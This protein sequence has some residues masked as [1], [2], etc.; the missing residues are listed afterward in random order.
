LDDGS[1]AAKD[2]A[3]AKQ[4]DPHDPTPWLYSAIHEQQENRFNSAV[5]ELRQSLRLNDNRQVYRSQFL[6]DEDRAVRSANLAKIYQH[7]GM[8]EVAVREATRAVEGDYSNASAHLFLA[9]SFDAL[10]DP[11]EIALRYETAWFNEQLLAHLLSP[12]GG[13]PLSQFV[14]Q[15]EYS[16]LLEADR[17]GGSAIIEARSD[18]YRSAQASVFGTRG[19]S[20]GGLDW[21]YRRD[22]GTRV[23]NDNTLREVSGQMK[24]QASAVDVIYGLVKWRNQKNGDLLQN[25]RNEPGNPGLRFEEKQEPGLALA[26]WNRR[27]AP[28]VHTLFLGG[29]L[30]A[31]Q[32][33]NTP[34]FIP[35]LLVR[36]PG[37]LQPEFLRPTA[38]GV[39][40]YT[41]PELRNATI[42]P[43]AANPDGSL[44]L[45][46]DFQ[47]ALAPFLGRGPVTAI[48]F[49]TDRRSELF[50][51]RKFEI[52]SGELQQIWQRRRNTLL[53]GGRWQSGNFDTRA[54]LDIT[55]PALVPFTMAPAVLQ[56]VSADFR[57]HSVYAY[58]FFRAVSWLTL[59]AG[60]SWE[61]QERPDNF[62]LPP[63]NDRQVKNE[64]TNG[65]L[66]FN[67]AAAKWLRIRGVYSE[68]TG[69]VTFDESVRLEPVQL[70]GFNQAFRT[71][72]SES[73]V[74]SVEGPVYRNAGMSL[75]GELSP[76][77]WWG[78]SFNNLEEDVE[79]T[80][81]ALDLIIAPVFPRGRAVLPG[82]ITQKL[83][84]R[85]AVA[86]ADVHQLIGRQ[87]AVGATYRFTRAELRNTSPE[88]PVVLNPY[89]DE[90]DRATFEELTLNVN[91]NAPSGW[92][93]RGEGNWYSQDL[94]GTAGDQV[95]I[96]L[97]GDH[98][99]HL[100]LQLG[101]RFQRNRHELSA[102]VLNLTDRDYHLSPLTYTRELPR[103]RTLF[104]RC[105]F[106]F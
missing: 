35:A 91:W 102:G 67:A 58:D 80:V 61:R 55:N 86:V 5:A 74:G 43:V 47:R 60:G 81:G 51:R 46:P 68:A 28:G 93:A 30:A 3:L 31:E 65:K 14:S 54:R 13:G 26:G 57:R 45:S 82:G 36:D 78:A 79:R 40:E 66:G 95:K 1:L 97:P 6:L 104:V 62:R 64:R 100:T 90:Y 85:E 33:L 89:A 50:T 25:Y 19:R 10:R 17:V 32:V 88:I 106:G 75:D 56:N 92:F 39:L 83:H 44:K 2:L 96:S 4:L 42:P 71:I 8:T 53:A 29:R 84:Y 101:R 105:R 63:V 69:G 98:F 12:V 23:N 70:A 20:S 59:I 7:N 72:I 24:F 9:N 18:G 38:N 15:H 94:H 27:W 49:F 48:D 77:A 76:R 99:W 103:E 21:W 37:F 16:K 22:Q 11:K 41:A 34:G 52:Y 73:L 87:F